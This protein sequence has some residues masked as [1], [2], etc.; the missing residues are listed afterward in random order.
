MPKR[1]VC[2]DCEIAMEIESVGA[3][4]LEMDH[5]ERPYQLWVCDLYTC[6]LGCSHQVAANHASVPIAQRGSDDFERLIAF[7]ESEDKLVRQ[8]CRPGQAEAAEP[9]DAPET[10]HILILSHDGC[11]TD[12]YGY[13]NPRDAEDAYWEYWNEHHGIE[14]GDENAVQEIQSHSR[15]SVEW[16]EATIRRGE[17]NKSER[18]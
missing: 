3:Y 1:P 13:H 16:T 17:V 18:G 10:L 14:R 7:A 6:R 9:V 2:A 12:V 8:Y 4:T 5:L 11:P 15:I